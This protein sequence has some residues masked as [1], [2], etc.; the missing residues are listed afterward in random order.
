MYDK[1]I[2]VSII[3]PVYNVKKYLRECLDSII[4]YADCNMEIICIDDGSIDGSYEILLEYEMRHPNIVRCMKHEHNKGLSV[5]RNTGLKYAQGKYVWFVD[6]DDLL[7]GENPIAF[8]YEI[9]EKY[10]TDIVFFDMEKFEGDMPCEH[11]INVQDVSLDNERILT[12]REL[13]CESVN[14]NKI[15]C[16]SWRQFFSKDFLLNNNLEFIPGL[17]HEDNVFW[18][19]CCMKAERV[20]NL[21]CKF[22]RYRQRLGSI[23]HVM[24]PKRVQSIFVVFMEVYLIW[25]QYYAFLTDQE[26]QA[27]AKYM[28][29]F[30][31]K[32]QCYR[33]YDEGNELLD[34]VDA[35]TGE[36]YNIVNCCKSRWL[37]I[38]E[39]E[40]EI[41]R[42]QKQIIVYG[43]GVAAKSVI[44]YLCKKH[45]KIEA[46]A[47]TNTDGNPTF[48]SNIPVK[49]IE[50][51]TE[52]RETAM[53]V[54]GVTNQYS[55]G[56]YEQLDKLGFDHI[57]E[58]ENLL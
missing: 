9:A 10:N 18:I 35:P 54:I 16:E 14:E 23:C 20:L 39:K 41:M 24:S 1:M 56:I 26:N 6:S 4:S 51:L 3:V 27:F 29:L 53:I 33:E 42:Q 49:A 32:W 44:R 50:Q 5:A 36:I 38:G 8:L 30:F 2:K 22:Y 52:Y 17:L 47:V 13:F 15:K 43:A 34:W 21:N 57:M 31:D 40:L 28:D 25:K 45:I 37:K 48:L 55:K 11:S 12:G 7:M 19:Q 58:L 46:V